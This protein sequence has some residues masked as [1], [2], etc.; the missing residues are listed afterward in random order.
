[1]IN[2]CLFNVHSLLARRRVFISELRVTATIANTSRAA[3]VE[4]AL[5]DVL[6]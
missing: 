1:M 3:K 6:K 2:Y 5:R 4:T